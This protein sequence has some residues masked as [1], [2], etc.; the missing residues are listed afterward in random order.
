MRFRAL[1]FDFDGLI[2]DTEIPEYH[3]VRAEFEAHGVE[4][5]LADW[6]EIIGRTDHLH[7]LDWLER[8]AAEPIEREI[9]RARRQA[10]HHALVL[11]QSI[12]PG[13]IELLDE[14]ESFGI[15]ATVASSSPSE[16]VEPHLE[17]LGILDRFSAV[18]T[19]DHVER[20]KPWPD[21][22]LAATE[23]VHVDPQDAV[24]FEDSRNGSLAAKAAGLFCVVV[25]NELTRTQD[26]SHVDLV[27]G[28]LAEITLTSL[29]A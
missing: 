15:P 3:T 23:A 5:R 9:V 7:W 25:P 4:L 1:V 11:Q 28:S 26:F 19:G 21:V 27:V 12:L 29:G 24:A 22:F 2:L 20:T 8:D 18:R 17:R 16:W 14:A 10:R 6:L 13:V